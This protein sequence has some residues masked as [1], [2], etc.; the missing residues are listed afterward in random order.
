MFSV[1]GVADKS[2][3]ARVVRSEALLAEAEQL[4]NLGS[5]EHDLESGLIRRSAN[6]CKMLGVD[7]DAETI[8]EDL[9]WDLVAP[10]DHEVVRR[11]IDQAT[12]NRQSYEYQARF[13]LPDG[14][15]RTFL[16]RGKPI[17][18]SMNR[19]VKR[20][21]VALDITGKAESAR[22]LRES[23][24]R[25]RDLVEN[26]NDLVCT[27][28]LEGRVLSMN[29]LPAKLLGYGPEDLVGHRIPE[30][31]SSDV[32][33]QFDAYME[34]I[35]RDGFA[36]G[37]MLLRTRSGERRIWEYHNTL[38]SEGVPSP[39]VRGIAHDITEQ[40]ETER[41]LRKS[42]SLLAQ[43]E[44]LANMGSWELDI[45]TQTLHWSAH[46]F[47]MLGLEAETGPV[48]YGHGIRMIHPDDRERAV[49]DA[50][51]MRDCTTPVENVLRFVRTDGSV[52]IFH[53]RA[54][55]VTDKTGR[56][57]RIRGMSQDVTDRKIEEER[58]RKSQAL[59]SQ[60]EEMANCGSWDFDLTSRTATLS[61]NFLRMYDMAS[62][63]EWAPNK[64]W[65]SLH[66]EDRK[67]ACQIMDR[68]IA[69]CE[70][71]EYVSRYIASDGGVRVH[72]LRGLSIP[73]EDGTTARLTGV[74]QDITEQVRAE[75]DL[76][77]LSQELM[78]IRDDERRRLARDLHESVGQSLAALKLTLGRTREQLPD[79]NAL[80][81]A[82]LKSATEIAEIAIQEVRTI[83]YLMYPPMLDEAG[84]GFALRW[85]AKGFE[86][87]SGIKLKVEIPENLE[88]Q[89]REIETTVFRIVQEALTNV[90]RYSGSRTATVRLACEN[91]FIKTEVQDGGSGIP[92][93]HLVGGSQGPLGL[94]I[95][96]MRERVNHLNGLFELN[97]IPGKGT[98]VR[99]ILPLPK[100]E[101]ADQTP[102]AKPWRAS[103]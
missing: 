49:H 68:A 13:V 93:F 36:K 79:D 98:T 52:R 15:R 99:V 48:P 87:R 75:D 35:Q 82:F 50:E 65:A 44:E 6:L 39:I 34:R 66:P 73:A 96:V 1:V 70:P 60:T 63:A 90:H 81:S 22:K 45:D 33:G 41:R 46:Y 18:D 83:S 101:G 69:A 91:G 11:T 19:V 56:L 28:D 88:R 54:I 7:P 51:Q 10:E 17:I 64:Y 58:L 85:Y 40:K 8:P 61:S 67:R 23:E 16:T 97:S 2:Q 84:L 94:G 89:S 62:E 95:Q 32:R 4:A 37:L 102:P 55:S 74:V 47:R 53:S 71:F 78:R 80:A 86:E 27:H 77:R 3:F 30:M 21:G 14:S 26:S 9:F 43:A 57:V 72:F 100:A 42:E 24:E 31:L 76:R 38:R 103:G 25:Y 29:E 20:I 12:M 5:W 92:R 59:L